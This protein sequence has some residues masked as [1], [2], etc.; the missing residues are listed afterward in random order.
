MIW[1]LLKRPLNR[2]RVG[3]ARFHNHVIK[4]FKYQYVNE[5]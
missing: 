5:L 4:C 3:K 2:K 1:Y